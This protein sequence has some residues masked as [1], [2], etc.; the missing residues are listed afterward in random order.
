MVPHLKEVVKMG[1]ELNTHKRKLLITAFKHMVGTAVSGGSLSPRSSEKKLRGNEKHIATL[2]GD[3]RMS[4]S[5][6]AGT[7]LDLLD[8]NLIPNGR[9]AAP[10]QRGGPAQMVM[11]KRPILSTTI[12]D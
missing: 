9:N 8:G 6:S 1:G 7:S 3:R 2:H 10:S 11:T 12:N 5:R 4:L